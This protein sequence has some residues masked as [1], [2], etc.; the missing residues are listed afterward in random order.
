MAVRSRRSCGG[1]AVASS[2][3]DAHGHVVT[4]TA[5]RTDGAGGRGWSFP[6]RR[7]GDDPDQVDRP[8]VALE[9]ALAA[10][11]PQMEEAP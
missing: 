8:V 6:R 3:R 4:A 7:H 11:S 10:A 2:S 9:G 1:R 5:N